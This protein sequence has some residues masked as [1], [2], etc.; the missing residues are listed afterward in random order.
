MLQSLTL[1]QFDNGPTE[2]AVLEPVNIPKDANGLS[3]GAY[4]SSF[5]YAS[6]PKDSVGL[7]RPQSSTSVGATSFHVRVVDAAKGTVEFDTPEGV[8]FAGLSVDYKD[9]EYDSFTPVS[10]YFICALATAT[11]VAGKLVPCKVRFMGF[12]TDGTIVEDTVQYTPPI[13]SLAKESMKFY[14]FPGR[15]TGVYDVV[16]TIDSGFLGLKL[17]SGLSTGIG[18]DNVIVDLNPKQ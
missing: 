12:K 9:S 16:I 7:F 15:F 11:T 5:A 8:P 2:P 4:F 14:E 1:T 13:V 6:V 3:H 10:C 17:V 18:F